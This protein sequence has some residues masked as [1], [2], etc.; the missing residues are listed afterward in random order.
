MQ[1]PTYYIPQQRRNHLSYQQPHHN[2][3]PRPNNQRPR[4]DNFKVAV[5]L[6]D[7]N[8]TETTKRKPAAHT[9]KTEGMG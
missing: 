6:I 1:Q 3:R 4:T 5:K 8:N 9:R 7:A 2:T